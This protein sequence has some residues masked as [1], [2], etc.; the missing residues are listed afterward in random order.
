[1]IDSL[2]P[3]ARLPQTDP[4]QAQ[5]VAHAEGRAALAL[6]GTLG[7][8]DWSRPTD[9]P[10]W[11]VRALVA[12]LVAQCQDSIH[13]A[14]M[15]RRELLSRRRYPDKPPVDAYMAVGVDDHR[16]ASGPQLVERSLGSVAPRRPRPPPPPSRPAPHHARPRHPRP[17]PLAPGLCAGCHL[18]PRPVDAPTRPGPGNRPAVRPG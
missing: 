18:Q 5:A 11:D 1:M 16:A 4:D 3:A 17:A 15:A 12:H 9:C 10:E 14:S 2:T 7:D 6:L 8:E 13:L